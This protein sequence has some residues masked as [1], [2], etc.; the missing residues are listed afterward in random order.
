MLDKQGATNILFVDLR[1]LFNKYLHF[2]GKS[3]NYFLY[4]S[5]EYFHLQF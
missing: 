5:W 1:C 3:C 4:R 2:H